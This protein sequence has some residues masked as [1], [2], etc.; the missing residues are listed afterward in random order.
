V[1]LAVPQALE[2][3]L[4]VHPSPAGSGC[5]M[6]TLCLSGWAATGTS[7]L[8]PSQLSEF[9]GW[10][11]AAAR[12]TVNR[13]GTGAGPGHEPF[14]LVVVQEFLDVDLF[15][16]DRADGHA[17]ADIDRCAIEQLGRLMFTSPFRDSSNIFRCEVTADL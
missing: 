14:D 8:S 13:G 16:A 5:W 9:I 11:A 6:S 7:S 3:W 4:K 12:P 15:S 2:A 10:S 1:P 17:S